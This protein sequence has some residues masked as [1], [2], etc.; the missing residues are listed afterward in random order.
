MN[1]QNFQTKLIAY[2][3]KEFAINIVATK[4]P[5]Q[6]MSS[7]VFFIKSSDN[8][9]YAVKYGN[10]AMKDI[11]ALDL[12]K[13]EHL[14][15]PV[16]KLFGSFLFEKIP[17][18]ILEKIHF[19]LLESVPINEISKYVPSMIKN[20]KKL[21]TIKSTTPGIPHEMKNEKTW[22]E[23]MLTIFRDGE[24]NWDEIANRKGVDKSLILL[25]VEKMIKKINNTLFED[26]I[27]SLLHTDFNQRNLFVD[28]LGDEITGIIDWEEAMFGDPIYD[29]ARIRMYLWHFNLDDK[30]IQTYYEIMNFAPEQKMLEDLYWLSRV[31]E[32]IGWY[33]KELNEFTINRITL[34]QNYLRTYHW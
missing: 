7:T 22:K 24:L 28:P 31:I 26:N 4:I 1:N 8:K 3:E 18:I 23:M 25:S 29:F 9:E 30:T 14:D 17:A 32:Y 34:H 6:G 10:D 19:P 11:P 21:H 15:I 33:S 20:L 27:Y 12:I 2:I 5:P 16:P 13:R